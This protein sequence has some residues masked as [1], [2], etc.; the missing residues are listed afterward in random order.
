MTDTTSP[1]QVLIVGA[2]PTG[3]T[4]AV[5]LTRYGIPVRVI[6]RKSR[7]SQHSKA[8]NLMQ[9]NQELVAALGLLDPLAAVS[10]HM[11]RLMV[12]AYGADLGPRTMRLT[13]S[14]HTDVLLC[15]QDRFETVMANGLADLG[16]TIEF[17][18]ELTALT[19]HNDTVSVELTRGG[20][21]ERARFGW[22]AG[23]DGATGISRS[24]TALDFTPQRTG[25]AIRQIDCQLSWRRLP[26][27]E[28]MWLF[29]FDQGFAVVVPLPDG[30]HRIL[31]IEPKDAFPARQPTLAEMQDKLREVTADDSVVLS[32][33][34]WSSYTDLAMGLAPALRDRRVF[35]VG[36]VGNPILPNGGQ[37]M[38][39][40]IADAYDLAWKLAAVTAHSAPD[41]LLD[42]YSTERHALRTKLQRAQYASLKYTTLKT[43]RLSRLA[44]RHLAEPALNLGG[45][46]RMAQAFSELTL[47][48]RRSPLTL[49]AVGRTGLRA[50]DRARDALTSSAGQPVQ[51]YQLLYAGA[52]I[53][54]AFSGRGRRADP[55]AAAAAV[56]EL[57]RPDLR[58]Y[59]IT[60]TWDTAGAA[61]PAALDDLD[62]EL[63][64][65]YGLRAPTLILIRPDGHI[66]ARVPTAQQDRLARYLRTWLPDARQHFTPL[67]RDHPTFGTSP[68]IGSVGRWGR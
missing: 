15:G 12:N 14:P 24:F 9:R 37:G 40:G 41:A 43:P 22:V 31:T 48:T 60:N 30:V 46:Y 19:Q 13:E 39:T 26:G 63:H 35:L 8:T 42:T 32:E 68:N 38:N 53:L 36:D 62:G 52:W 33:E 17:G 34:K 10:G 51:L 21:V 47:H 50:G 5:G 11:R 23:C 7:L 59:L 65:T 66:A 56:L 27:A 67:D 44:F 45:E 3:L 64:R 57:G 16:V 4:L 6:E 1:D 29:Y 2:G 49:D 55:Q 25:V 28:Q 18:T 54:L 61:L 20:Q 58:T